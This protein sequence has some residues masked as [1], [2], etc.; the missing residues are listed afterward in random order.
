MVKEMDKRTVI[1]YLAFVVGGIALLCASSMAQKY[2]IMDVNPFVTSGYLVPALFGGSAGVLLGFLWLKTKRL[3]KKLEHRVQTLAGLLPIC[4]NCKK[5]RDDKG[6]WEH[7]EKYLEQHSEATFS[8]G[9][10]PECAETLYGNEE[11]FKRL[12]NKPSGETCFN[13]R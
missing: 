6:Y 11:W 13:V 12:K 7:L 3:N 2:F 9:I 5:I 1:C 4:A 10:C 8:H